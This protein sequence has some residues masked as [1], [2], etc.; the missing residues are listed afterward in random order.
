MQ[1]STETRKKGKSVKTKGHKPLEKDLFGLV[2]KTEGMTSMERE[3]EG[4]GV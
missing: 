1:K 4:G 3:K 2:C